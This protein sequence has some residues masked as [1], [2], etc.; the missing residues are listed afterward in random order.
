MSSCG[1]WLASSKQFCSL[2]HLFLDVHANKHLSYF[3]RTLC[4][5]VFLEHTSGSLLPFAVVWLGRGSGI[6]L[7]LFFLQAECIKTSTGTHACV[8]QQGWTGN[9]RDCVEINNCLLPGTGGCHDNA[10]CLYVGPGQVGWTRSSQRK[11]ASC[12]DFSSPGH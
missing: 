3:H 2:N 4:K 8:C 11:Q 10:T 5:F 9:G 7:H 1:H 6:L 12:S